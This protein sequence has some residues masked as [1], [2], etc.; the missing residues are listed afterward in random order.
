MVHVRFVFITGLFRAVVVLLSEVQKIVITF[1][2]FRVSNHPRSSPT[3][4]C[5]VWDLVFLM[6]FY[7][8]PTLYTSKQQ[9]KS[10]R[11]SIVVII[12]FYSTSMPPSVLCFVEDARNTG[13]LSFASQNAC[14]S[15]QSFIQNYA[16]SSSTWLSFSNEY[17]IRFPAKMQPCSTNC[18]SI[19]LFNKRN[20]RSLDSL[21]MFFR[22]VVS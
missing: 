10:E 5:R 21:Y 3:A 6:F 22:L 2:S 11:R 1:H 17:C 4:S 14:W 13:T 18:D 8:F 15:L 20:N 9:P 12:L 19:I 16:F 7:G